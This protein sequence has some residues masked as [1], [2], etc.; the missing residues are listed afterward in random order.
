MTAGITHVVVA[1]PARDEEALLPASLRALSAA[2][3]VLEAARPD[4]RVA[5][6]VALDGCTDGSARV[7]AEAGVAVTTLA[8]D[9]VGAARDAAVARGLEVLGAPEESTTW[10]ACTDADTVVPP[11]WLL[12]QVRWA[13]QGLDLVV[14]TAEPVGVDRP[15]ML[16]AWHARHQ[17]VEGHEHVHGANLGVRASRWREVGGFG[18]LR[19]GEDVRLVERVRAVSEQWVATDTTRVLTS[20]RSRSR[21]GAG[22]AGYLSDLGTGTG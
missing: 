1:V 20:G 2:V 11:R 17:L 14:G 19:L 6:A 22:F 4:V 15:E 18:P 12:R 10:L 21:V 7:A 8:G 3:A 16:A 13:D 9:G 5:V